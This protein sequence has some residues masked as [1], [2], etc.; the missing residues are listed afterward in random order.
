MQRLARFPLFLILMG[1]TAVAMVFPSIHAGLLAD[2]RIAR[3]FLFGAVLLG[4]LTALIALATAGRS[5]QVVVR[6]QLLALLS[7]Y[8][9]LPLFMAVPLYEAM[10][11][12]LTFWDAWFEMISAITTTGATIFD[13]P[14][15]VPDPIHFWRAIVGWLGGFLTWVAAIGIFA[16]MNLG[17]FELRPREFRGAGSLRFNQ[18]SD[19]VGPAERLA[20][21]A[22]Q[23][24][25][26]Y[27]GLTGLVWILLVA[28]GDSSFVALCHAM[29]TLSTSAISPVSTLSATESGLWGEVI[30]FGFLFFALSRGTFARGLLNEEK[31]SFGLDPEIRLGLII[32]L[33]VSTLLFLRHWVGATTGDEPDDP[34]EALS[35][36]WGSVFSVLS[37]LTTAGFETSRWEVARFWSGLE[38][39]GLILMGL[40]LIGGGVATTAGGVKLLRVYALAKHG[41]REIERLMSPNLVGGSGPLARHIRRQ[42]AHIAW[43]FFMLFALS[44]AATMLAL[45]LLGQPFERSIV[46]TIAAITTTGPLAHIAGET[47]IYYSTLTADVRAVLGFAMVLGRLETLAIIALFNPNIWRR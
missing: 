37:F 7:A 27:A 25:P 17:G 3:V 15:V 9:V 42:G 26:I 13:V 41:R 34:A 43:I 23:L 5:E 14:G 47:P 33:L 38:S 8:T 21:H 4:V 2:D 11:G 24:L 32:V 44:I 10:E 20:R 22:G 1:I 46:L 12:A 30:I 31:S 36:L 35:A 19:Q 39:P 45:S 40:A 29:S 6:S 16:P 28:A 18:I